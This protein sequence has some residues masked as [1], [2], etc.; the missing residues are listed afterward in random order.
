MSRY[1]NYFLM[2]PEDVAGYIVEK[3]PD[4]FPAG[5]DFESKEIGDGNINYV[6]KVADRKS[7][8]SII[9]KQAGVE[10]RI[11]KDIR[12]ST[13]RGRIEATILELEE[14]YAPGL[15][16]RVFLYDPVMCVMVMEDMI[17][18]SM[19]R[20][21]VMRHEVFPDFAEHIS[22]F[23]ANTLLMTTDV[24]MNHKE[25]KELV[26]SF[27]NPDLCEISEDLVY[28]EPYN[29]RMGRNNV[30]PPNLE[31]VRRELYGDDALKLE[32]AKLKFD[33][34]N[35]A[36]SLIHGDLH[37]GSI[38]INPEH[39]FVFDPEFAFYGPMGYDVGNIIANMCFVWANADATMDAAAGQAEYK[40]WVEDTIRR[41]TDLF[42]EKFVRLFRENVAE[43]MAK[44]P[45]FMEWYL[46][47][48]MADT[49]AVCGLE[50]NR[51][52][53]G[54]ANVKD[55]TTIPDEAK[56]ARAERIMV[57][58]AKDCIMNRGSFAKGDDYLD[59]LRRAVAKED[60][61]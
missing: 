5:A 20:T 37:T 46:G 14:K 32:V 36:Q 50:L 8:K 12:L 38:F 49:A 55:I 35:N 33:F 18:H 11:S 3:L 10:T 58:L 34:M 57:Y 29:D 61:N 53:V 31:F 47:T 30:F 48:V 22:T 1:D 56:R 28:T 40:K 6:F 42:V 45:G 19:M 41:I 27:I 7:G 43:P 15:V 21:A 51:R 39:T 24:V 26:K 16:P 9:V 59:A 2:H 44:T 54:M 52:I 17:G 23:M 4:F 25:K 13:D 60:G